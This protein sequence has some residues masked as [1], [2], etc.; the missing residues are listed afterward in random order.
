MGS[1]P[2]PA[3]ILVSGIPKDS[4]VPPGGYH[5]IEKRDGHP[6]LRIEGSNYREV[7]A[8]LLRHRLAN[9]VDPG[10]PL[11]EVYAFVCSQ[12]PHFCDEQGPVSIAAQKSPGGHPSTQVLHWLNQ[13]WK[14]QAGVPRML[15]SDTKARARAETCANCPMQRSWTDGGCGACIESAKQVGYVYRA[16]KTTGIDNSLLS[17]KITQQDNKTA[18]WSDNLPDLTPEQ[19]AAL[20]RTCWRARE[21]V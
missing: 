4:I 2:T 12:W 1:N 21:G 20:P 3:P 19:R 10:D 7:A 18:V 16:G 8:A 9:K 15:V 11:N 5:F 17:C 6:D 14:R 13:L